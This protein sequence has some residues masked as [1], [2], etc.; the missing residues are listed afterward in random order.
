MNF[1]EIM[2]SIGVES[3]GYAEPTL[4]SE[5]MEEI[6]LE[7]ELDKNFAE[8][9]AMNTIA[10]AD[11][12]QAITIALV[13]REI[14]LE[15][16]QGRDAS[17]I[18]Q[19]FGLEAI[20]DVA[21]RKYYGGLASIKALIN[22]CISWL[23]NLVGI[24]TSS[25]KIFSGLKKKADNQLKALRK[26]AGKKTDKLNREM[27]EY[28]GA[29]KKLLDEYS[30]LKTLYVS[31]QTA[32]EATW[33]VFKKS[34]VSQSKRLLETFINT[35]Q[36][37][38][39]SLKTKKENLPDIYDRSDKNE[40]EEGSAYSHIVDVM[41]DIKSKADAKKADTILKDIEKTIKNLEKFRDAGLKDTE[42]ATNNNTLIDSVRKY[43]N[44]K[45]TLANNQCSYLKDV[46][47][48]IVRLADD[49]LTDAKA[50]EAA[51]V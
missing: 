22:T 24:A 18:F 36:N 43:I 7:S 40:Y 27:H 31:S 23:K 35:D 3:M 21:A 38:I 28:K 46:L 2:N 11:N 1:A 45:I 49:A 19:D 16:N 6:A 5:L 48:H 50:I 41:Q 33:D 26:L 51:L 14:A 17:V 39:D 10:T 9:D 15:S 42:W 13:E 44:V 25:K 30:G 47:K 20:K 4:E 34:A 12:I 37:K 32:K 8:M 29:L